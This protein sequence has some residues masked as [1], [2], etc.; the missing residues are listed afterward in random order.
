[1]DPVDKVLL[2]LRIRKQED[3]PE[4]EKKYTKKDLVKYLKEAL[5][6]AKFNETFI[7]LL[8][9]YI[10][11]SFEEKELKEQLEIKELKGKRYTKIWV[12]VL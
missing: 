1:M 7:N 5:E 9:E 2:M 6:L 11:A 12:K 4:E 10:L 3:F 8:I